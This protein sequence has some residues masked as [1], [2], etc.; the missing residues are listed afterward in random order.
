MIYTERFL[1]LYGSQTFTA[2]EVAERI[3]RTTKL[4]GFKGPVQAMDDFSISK[5]IHEEFALFVCSTTGQG[6][7][8]DNM[9]RFWKFLLR[10]NLP[11][12]SLVK[13]K[14]GVIGLGDSSYAKFNFVAKKLHKRLIQLGATPILDL[15]LCDYQ[16]DLGHDAVL[17]PWLKNFL[18]TLRNYFPNLP[19]DTIKSS[20]VPRWKI[21]LIKTGSHENGAAFNEDIYFRNGLKDHFLDTSYFEVEKNIRTTDETHFQDVRLI[22]LKVC[23]DKVLDYKPGDV[24]NIRPRNSK[25]DVDDLFEIFDTHNLDIKP[26]YRLKVEQYHDDMPVQEFFKDPLTMYEIAEQYWDLKA[27]PTQYVFSLLALVSEDKLEKEKCLELSSAEGQEDWLNYSRR[28]KRTILEVLHDFHKSASK[29]TIDVL[30]ELFCSIKPRSFSIASSCLSSNGTKLE[31]L[32]AVV[33]YYSKLKRARLGLA[34]NWLKSLQNG[35]KV[36][37]WIKKGS[38]KFPEDKDIPQIFVAPGTGLAPFRSLLQEKLYDGTA[39]K[40]VLHLFFGC[41]YKEKDFHCKEELEKMVE[42]KQLSLYTAFSR[43]Q[44]NKIYVQHKIA[45]V[46]NE[47]WHLINN[48]GAYIFISGNAKNMPDNVRDAFIDVFNTCGDID[49][50]EAKEMLKDIEKNGRLQVETW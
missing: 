1:V 25:E 32:V 8:P 39:N 15:A 11:S 16:H 24:F 36:Y 37:G 31:L 27:Y 49:M 19:T 50:A 34:S 4:L 29:L 40:D 23:E 48:K 38:L 6:D 47:L 42:D 13:L 10:K 20:F 17:S 44:D 21:S 26:Y 18:A 9:K 7:E 28:P 35:D 46:S 3:W 45:E 22:T 41:R 30:F 14:F 5:L 33:K 12:N 2:Q 43:D